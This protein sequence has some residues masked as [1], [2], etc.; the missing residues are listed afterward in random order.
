VAEPPTIDDTAM[1]VGTRC[2]LGFEPFLGYLTVS[3]FFISE[4]HGHV[5]VAIDL[6]A[7]GMEQIQDPTR[8]TI[9]GSHL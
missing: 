8:L 5:M 3:P 9:Y 4:E 2:F 1:R 6:D 7:S